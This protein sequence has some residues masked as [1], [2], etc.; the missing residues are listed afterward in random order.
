LVSQIRKILRT[1]RTAQHRAVRA[2]ATSARLIATS[3]I[4]ADHGFSGWS[5]SSTSTRRGIGTEIGTL[6]VRP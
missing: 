2:R 4:F 3:D 5:R 6:K 1:A